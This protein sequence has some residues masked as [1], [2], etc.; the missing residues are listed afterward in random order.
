MPEIYGDCPSVAGKSDVRRKV[1]RIGTWKSCTRCPGYRGF[2]TGLIVKAGPVDVEGT[3]LRE[4]VLKCE[5]V[6]GEGS[7]FNAEVV[8]RK[9]L[10][11]VDAS[12]LLL[13]AN[14]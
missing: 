3:R 8:E 11:E 6:I 7:A 2:L 13:S 9:Y 4:S 14:Q 1:R 10:I 5:I 12:D